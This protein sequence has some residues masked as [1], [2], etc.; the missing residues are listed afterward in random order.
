MVIN[1]ELSPLTHQQMHQTWLT[2]MEEKVHKVDETPKRQNVISEIY[3]VH[4]RSQTEDG[5]QL[6]GRISWSNI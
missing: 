3:D 1:V 5:Q 4:V 6:R 2:K